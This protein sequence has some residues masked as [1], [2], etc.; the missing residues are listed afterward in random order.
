MPST[1][2]EL[3]SDFQE[4]VKLYH[5]NATFSERSFMRRI[6]RAASEFQKRTKIVET[7][8][9]LYNANN[10]YIGDDVMQIVEICDQNDNNFLSMEYSQFRTALERLGQDIPTTVDVNGRTVVPIGKIF[11]KGNKEETGYYFD[12]V[13][14][15]PPTGDTQF[16]QHTRWF[17][18]Y[19][20]SI[21][22]YPDRGDDWL[23]MRYIPDIHPYGSNSSQWTAWFDNNEAKFE[24]Y[25]K[26][27]GLWGELSKYEEAIL[28]KAVGGFIGAQLDKEQK[29]MAMNEF[30]SAVNLA[31]DNKPQL[32]KIGVATYH[33]SPL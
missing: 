2:L 13:R 12:Q 7:S 14:H 31:T 11:L 9:V 32:Y 1:Y 26:N 23:Q 10:F 18:L 21:L 16:G 33:V 20:G 15:P 17:T 8:K 27:H 29:Y 19:E 6:T 4:E 24:E 28:K 30:K 5:Q 25:F 3:Y 22:I